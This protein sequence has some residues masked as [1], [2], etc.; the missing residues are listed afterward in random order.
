MKSCDGVVVVEFE[1]GLE[2]TFVTRRGWRRRRVEF[3]ELFGK[4]RLNKNKTIPII[5][6]FRVSERKNIC[7]QK[8]RWLR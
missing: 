7:N 2:R 4:G 8:W 3:M 6:S 1:A 5:S